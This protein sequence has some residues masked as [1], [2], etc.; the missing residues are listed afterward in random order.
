MKRVVTGRDS[1]GK[2]VFVSEGPPVKGAA[3]RGVPSFRIDVVWGTEGVPTL[4]PTP[5]DP[6]TAG[7]RFFPQA[8]GTRFLVVRFP[9]AADLEAAVANGADMAAAE[10]EFN[11]NFPG[12]AESMEGPQ[13]PGMHTTHTVDYGVVISG[14]M[15]LELDDGKQV[16]LRPGDCV[17]QNGTRHAW[18]NLSGREA[19]MA[20]VA[21]GAK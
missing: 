13:A 20:F 16:H 8:G 19:V 3:M 11:A 12:L 4:P 2:S 9:P 14:E 10:S 17:V 21:V 7:Q 18:R 5:G 6:T 1:S 15:H